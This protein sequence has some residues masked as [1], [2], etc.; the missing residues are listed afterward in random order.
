[1]ISNEELK[2][3]EALCEKASPEPWDESPASE[4]WKRNKPANSAFCRASRTMVPKLIEEVKEWRK[5]ANRT[6]G[7]TNCV[8][9]LELDQYKQ[10]VEVMAEAIKKSRELQLRQSRQRESFHVLEEVL[11]NPIVKKVLEK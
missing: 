9:V 11:N 1:M 10:A 6:H 8:S 7:Y 3:F 2:E 4:E 5:S